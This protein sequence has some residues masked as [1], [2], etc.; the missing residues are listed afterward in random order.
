MTNLFDQQPSAKPSTGPQTK[1]EFDAQQNMTANVRVQ[2]GNAGAIMEI[3]DGQ[4]VLSSRPKSAVA[5]VA[6]I[7]SRIIS[8]NG[9]TMSRTQYAQLLNSGSIP[10]G[11]KIIDPMARMNGGNPLHDGQS[12]GF[13]PDLTPDASDPKGIPPDEAEAEAAAKDAEVDAK[14]EAVF[15]EGQKAIDSARATIGADAVDAAVRTV[16]ETG[17]ADEMIAQLSTQLP[18]QQATKVLAAYMASAAEMVSDAGITIS[19]MTL[20][21]GDNDLRDARQAVVHGDTARMQF[22]ASKAV[23]TLASLPVKDPS[24]FEAYIAV[25]YPDLETEV[26]NGRTVVKVQHGGKSDWMPW[27]NLVRGGYLKNAK[28]VKSEE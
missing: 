24:S 19:D 3:V 7:D 14:T 16:V 2:D 9:M 21:L 1:A 13:F 22:I 11:A 20:A 27:D 10:P 18:P 28:L 5:K 6:D 8:V 26:R 25:R 4:F 12:D 17:D 15:A 23:D